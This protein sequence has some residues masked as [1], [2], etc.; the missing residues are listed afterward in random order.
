MLKIGN[1]V[2]NIH[3]NREGVL[4]YSSSGASVSGRYWDAESDSW[5]HFQT[6]GDNINTY[7]KDWK[8]IY[9]WKYNMKDYEE[10]KVKEDV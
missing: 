7:E 8:R 6:L 3:N 5:V 4:V 10:S 9:K 1:K 2:R